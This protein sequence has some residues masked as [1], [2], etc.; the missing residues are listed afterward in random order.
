MANET[1]VTMIIDF[2]NELEGIEEKKSLFDIIRSWRRDRKE[3]STVY[4]LG[5]AN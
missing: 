4:S 2:R 1:N 5:Y 3:I